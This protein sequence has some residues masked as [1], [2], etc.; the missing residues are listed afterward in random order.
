[1]RRARGSEPCET[2][3]VSPETVELLLSEKFRSG[4]VIGVAALVGGGMLGVLW[5]IR[6]ATPVPAAG[7]LIT[8]A[9]YLALQG[10]VSPAG[11]LWQGLFLLLLG[12]TLQRRETRILRVIAWL[13]I[14]AGGW[15][16]LET[17]PVSDSHWV[18]W[19]GLLVILVAS[20]AVAGIDRFL[21][22]AAL[23]PPLFGLSV[24]GIFFAVPDT[25]APLML[26]S[27]SLPIAFMGWP[28]RLASLGSP[29]AYG[30]VGLLVWA[31]VTGGYGRPG[32][33]VGAT[34]CLGVLLLFP[35]AWFIDDRDALPPQKPLNLGRVLSLVATHVV[36][37]GLA[38]RVVA[39]PRSPISVAGAA[40]L[41]ML[42]GLGLGK[43]ANAR[44]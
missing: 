43:W 13:F 25:E 35:M 18:G 33:L 23:G 8:A 30:S 14:A 34:L 9:G 41:L 37:V 44:R 24:V 10:L 39:A 2:E 5:R 12:G 15:L 32:S 19:F 4:L 3:G 17:T 7:L 29:G 42:L 6:R 22:E 38:S 28:I 20:P 11:G 40:L 27:V 26:M 16:M 36:L 21:A 1:M 31:I